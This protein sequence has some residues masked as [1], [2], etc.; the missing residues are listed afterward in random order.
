MGSTGCLKTLGIL[1][2]LIAMPVIALFVGWLST[3]QAPSEQLWQSLLAFMVLAPF[4]TLPICSFFL[5][6]RF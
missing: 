6:K 2:C 1:S 5:L 4:F 3:M